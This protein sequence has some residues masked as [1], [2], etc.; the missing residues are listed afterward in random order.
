MCNG[1]NVEG[2]LNVLLAAREAGVRRVVYASSCAIY[3][4]S[5]ALPL[6]EESLGAPLSP[7]AASKLANEIYAASFQHAYG[8]STVGLRYFNVFGPRQDPDGAYAA[9]IPRWITNLLDGIRCEIHGDGE[10]SRDF[11]HV[12]NVAQANL[13]A[14]MSERAG[15]RPAVYNVAGGRET[16][17]NELFRMIRLGLAGYKP[18]IAC[19]TPRFGPARRGD[20]RRSVA[21]LTSIRRE[22][23]Y[24]PTH[25][26]AQGLGQTLEWYV[27]RSLKG[28]QAEDSRAV[29]AG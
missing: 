24:Q 22:L 14:A 27:E 23:E 19:A 16:T 3:G 1:V 9:V 13:L 10:T 29:A 11:C 15:E 26:T 20:I 18:L 28:E 2:F 4:D 7:Y 12:A 25:G 8:L 17:L 6:R 21:D 5:D